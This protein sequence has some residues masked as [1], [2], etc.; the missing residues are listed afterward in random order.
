MLSRLVR[1]FTGCPLAAVLLWSIFVTK[2]RILVANG[3]GYMAGGG[4]SGLWSDVRLT[5]RQTQVVRL[6]A[7]GLSAKEIARRLR[8]SKR[9]VEEHF[10]AARK[11]TGATSK[12][13][14][15]AWW[16]RAAVTERL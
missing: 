11:R 2:I 7:E 8:I 1:I 13:A 12:A 3:G 6:A 9:T 4:S 15:V 16:L 5:H 14:L 10:D